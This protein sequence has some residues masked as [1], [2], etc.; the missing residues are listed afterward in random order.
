MTATERLLLARCQRRA[1]RPRH[2]LL[3]S[4]RTHHTRPPATHSCPSLNLRTS[5][6]PFST[7]PSFIAPHLFFTPLLHPVELGPCTFSAPIASRSFSASTSHPYP[8]STCLLVAVHDAVSVGVAAWAVTSLTLVPYPKQRLASPLHHFPS[9]LLTPPLRRSMSLWYIGAGLSI[10][11]SI[12]SNLGINIQKYSF[13]QNAQLPI[14]QQRAYTKQPGWAIGLALVILGSVGD[15]AALA[16]AA[17]SIITPIGSVTL[18]ANMVFAHFWLKETL[19]RRDMIGTV[20]IIAGSVLTVSFG[21]HSDPKYNLSDFRRF[22][23]LTSSL[24]YTFIILAVSSAMYAVILYLRPIKSRIITLTKGYEHIQPDSLRD[25]SMRG[26]AELTALHARYV[27]WEK[28]HPFCYCAL[29][30]LLGAQSVLFGKMVSELISTSIQGD[31]QL[32][33]VFPYIFL[34]CMLAFVFS[35]LHFLALALTYFDALYCVPIFQCFFILTSTIGGAAFFEEF[36]SF[37]VLQMIVFPVG[38]ATTLL[39]VF[40]LAQR[41][42]SSVADKGE[43]PGHHVIPASLATFLVDLDRQKAQCR[44]VTRSWSHNWQHGGAMSKV[45]QD[46]ANMAEMATA[47]ALSAQKGEMKLSKEVEE[48]VMREVSAAAP[49][50]PSTHKRRDS[51][52]LAS[53]MR[54]AALN[55]GTGVG[56]VARE[57][58][59]T[60]PNPSGLP[61]FDEALSPSVAAAERSRRKFK[62]RSHPTHFVTPSCLLPQAAV[63]ELAKGVVVSPS[64]VR[65]VGD[66]PASPPV[67]FGSALQVPLLSPMAARLAAVADEGLMLKP[68]AREHSVPVPKHLQ[69]QEEG[70]EGGERKEEIAAVDTVVNVEAASQQQPAS[71]GEPLASVAEQRVRSP[72]LPGQLDSIAVQP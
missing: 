58:G 31:N 15:F 69:Q 45:Q 22:F 9:S 44:Q 18:V 28:V 20:L 5:A 39:G 60:T 56:G 11:G 38:I 16:L 13:L 8:S 14:D 1:T 62:S 7:C 24:L 23:G 72:L 71:G 6:H 54:P 64:S 40:L 41:D 48:S 33:S 66:V 63:E 43:G 53:S 21:D 3:A 27:R 30:G 4:Q 37:T 42:S 12:G 26:N 65:G 29:S 25:E 51:S 70:E 52:Q 17:Q 67:M 36:A 55:L 49:P 32:L 61:S 10:L 2:P 46:K 19:S 34:V 59:S 50:Q 57:A 47:A 68:L 35:Q